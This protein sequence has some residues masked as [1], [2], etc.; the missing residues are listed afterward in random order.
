MRGISI[1]NHI[2]T[3]FFEFETFE[4][5]NVS[6]MPKGNLGRRI[7]KCRLN[8]GLNSYGCKT[9]KSSGPSRALFRFMIIVIFRKSFILFYL[10]I[11]IFDAWNFNFK[12]YN[13]IFF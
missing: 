5:L 2:T 9:L 3:F 13:N 10:K 1:L 7:R 8:E 11:I 4:K 6:I 12:S